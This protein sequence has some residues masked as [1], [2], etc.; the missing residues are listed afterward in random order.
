MKYLAIAATTL[1]LCAGGASAVTITETTDYTNAGF[2]P[3]TIGTLST[4]E[5]TVVQGSIAFTCIQDET[6]P[7]CEI[8]DYLDSFDLELPSGFELDSFSVAI[9]NFQT[10]GDVAP[11][12]FADPNIPVGFAFAGG[13][14][15][16]LAVFSDNGTFN[17]SDPFDFSGSSFVDMQV[18]MTFLSGNGTVDFDYEIT[19]N[20]VESATSPSPVPLP[21]GLPLLAVGLIGLGSLARRNK[22]A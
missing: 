20:V 22:T 12:L 15:G 2:P 18:G 10:T 17:F 1:A 7:N 3:D 5:A 14:G 21:A 6:G 11:E 16:E 13:S 9:S 4:T 8:G 19:F